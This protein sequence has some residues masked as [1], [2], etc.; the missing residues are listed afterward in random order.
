M[1]SLSGRRK[2]TGIKKH[3]HSARRRR[4][5]RRDRASG[6]CAGG[7]AEVLQ[8]HQSSRGDADKFDFY[9]AHI[10][11]S[12]TNTCKIPSPLFK[13]SILP[14]PTLRGTTEPQHSGTSDSSWRTPADRTAQS[15][16]PRPEGEKFPSRK[17]LIFLFYE[18][19]ERETSQNDC[20]L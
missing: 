3:F 2:F 6:C 20:V 4:I 9:S 1:E 10:C 11:N 7:E 16:A 8:L 5:R 12:H 18:D 17:E 13:A 15:A 14:T 19:K